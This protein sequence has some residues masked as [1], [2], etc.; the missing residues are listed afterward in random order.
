[1]A[2]PV[3][4]PTAAHGLTLTARKE[5]VGGSRVQ[6][7]HLFVQRMT[8]FGNLLGL[9]AVASLVDGGRLKQRGAA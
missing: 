9:L 1:M 6:L 8:L 7:P 5:V 3:A 4:L 2:L